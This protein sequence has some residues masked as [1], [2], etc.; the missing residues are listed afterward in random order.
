MASP[1]WWID[2]ILFRGKLRQIIHDGDHNELSMLS[3]IH[4]VK[5][6]SKSYCAIFSKLLMN[7]V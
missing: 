1:S 4:E 5:G 2:W 3:I 6:E 7:E